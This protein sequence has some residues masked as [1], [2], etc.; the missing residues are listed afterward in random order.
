MIEEFVARR[1]ASWE[2]LE[3]LLRQA[4]GRNGHSMSAAELEELGRAY[5]RVTS[6]LAVARRDFPQDR[7]ARYLE[8]LAGRAHPVVY[9]REAAGWAEV[10]GFFA[11]DFPRAFQEAGPYTALAFLLFAIPFTASFLAVLINP[12]V[13][14]IMPLPPDFVDSVE[15]GQ[16]W[17]QITGA[18]RSLAASMIMTNNIQVAFLAFAGGALLGLGTV[19]VLMEN[20]LILGAVAGMAATH[21]LGDAMVGFVAAHGG[22]ELTVVFIAGGAGLRLGH[23]ILSPG[24]LSRPAALAEAARRSIRLIF[25][26]AP[27]LMIAGTLEGFISP[28]SLPIAAKL[29]IGGTATVLLYVYL[30]RPIRERDTRPKT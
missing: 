22:I 10:K 29:A 4:Q 16:N 12:L 11:R 30:L 13:G 18:E 14:R 5:R 15:R 19:Y 28:S 6:D 2:R 8:Q 21:G 20:G 26:C 17:M 9:R 27:L 25:G 23:S 24:L 7:V 1:R 3:A